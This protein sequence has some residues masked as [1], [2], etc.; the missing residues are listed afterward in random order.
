MAQMKAK[1][2]EMK[3]EKEEARKVSTKISA[4]TG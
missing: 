2:K 1:E 4:S 3:D